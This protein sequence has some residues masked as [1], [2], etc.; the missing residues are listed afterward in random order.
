MVGWQG[1]LLVCRRAISGDL[2]SPLALVLEHVHPIP[3]GFGESLL[4]LAH[5]CSPTQKHWLWKAEGI[6]ISRIVV[7][8]LAGTGGGGGGGLS[9]GAGSL[10]P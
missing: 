5:S 1:G 6:L 7:S 8:H 3:V 2:I 9:A 4:G 10:E